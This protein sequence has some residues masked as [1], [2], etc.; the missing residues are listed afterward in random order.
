MFKAATTILQIGEVLGHCID[1][2]IS[3]KAASEKVQTT[4]SG[5]RYTYLKINVRYTYL[6]INVFRTAILTLIATMGDNARASSLVHQVLCTSATVWQYRRM[7]THFSL[8]V[9]ASEYTCRPM[10]ANLLYS[11]TSGSG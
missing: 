4:V 6:K 5:N 2:K 8:R 3:P 11:L 9:S 1:A 10:I 7:F